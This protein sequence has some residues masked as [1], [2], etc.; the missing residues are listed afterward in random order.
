[1]ETNNEQKLNSFSILLKEKDED[2]KQLRIDLENVQNTPTKTSKEFLD[3][4]L[5]AVNK[6]TKENIGEALEPFVRSQS[7]SERRVS[8][9]FSF[10]EE[11]IATIAEVLKSNKS[12]H[13]PFQCDQCDRVFPNQ[14]S[15]QNH[16]KTIHLPNP[17]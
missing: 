15:L 7:Q 9:Q 17:T 5:S 1:M 10:I 14:R 4:V 8:E 12:N 2:I 3:V 16:R 11:Q 13:Q 6:L